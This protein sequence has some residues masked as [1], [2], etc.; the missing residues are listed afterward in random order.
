MVEKHEWLKVLAHF[1]VQILE[2]FFSRTVRRFYA[3]RAIQSTYSTV[4]INIINTKVSSTEVTLIDKISW[5]VHNVQ[6]FAVIIL[7]VISLMISIIPSY[8]HEE[9]IT[10]SLLKKQEAFP[11][12]KVNKKICWYVNLSMMVTLMI[13]KFSFSCNKKGSLHWWNFV[14]YL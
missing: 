5:G 13:H 7:T 3:L 14:I 4:P 11:S 8:G 12:C 1:F 9:W 6:T 10:W 2:N